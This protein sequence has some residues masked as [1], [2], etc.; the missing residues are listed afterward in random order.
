MVMRTALKSSEPIMLR[1]SV[2]ES[3]RS[4]RGIGVGFSTRL[5]TT[6]VFVFGS[7]M[8]VAQSAPPFAQQLAV[9]GADFSS[10]LSVR[11]LSDGQVL[12]VDYQKHNLLTLLNPVTKKKVRVGAYGEGP[13]EYESLSELTALGKDSTVMLQSGGKLWQLL[14]RDSVIKLPDLARGKRSPD[15]NSFA[16]MDARWNWLRVVGLGGKSKQ[17]RLAPLYADSIGL[18]RTSVQGKTDTLARLKGY[19]LGQ[20]VRYPIVNGQGGL[21]FEVMNP[22]T[23]YEQAKLFRDGTIAIALLNPYRVDWILDNGTRL[24]GKPLE[25]SVALSTQAK[26]MLASQHMLNRDGTAVFKA[27]DFPP[28][29]R[30]IPPFVRRALHAGADGRLYVLRT[31]IDKD[32]PS[33]YDVFDRAGK[34]TQFRLPNRALLV[35]SGE[36]GLYVTLK[37]DDDVL[38]LALFK[39]PP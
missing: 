27:S 25:A 34:R 8:A 2:S 19:N 4:R 35:G 20:V 37:D 16:G 13:G 12:L 24:R 32:G 7:S 23:T 26:E 22:L 29:P 18:I 38:S 17:S 5:I 10:I 21:N 3:S 11:E 36:R 14:R 39:Y 9:I 30:D 33:T 1:T 31:I 15:G 28:F 6:T